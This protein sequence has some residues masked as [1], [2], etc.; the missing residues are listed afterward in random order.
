MTPTERRL[1]TLAILLH[2]VPFTAGVVAI[3]VQL[4]A[5]IGR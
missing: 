4:I 1:G 3:A 5:W 2:V